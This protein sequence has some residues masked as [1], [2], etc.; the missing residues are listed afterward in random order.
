M[1][2]LSAPAEQEPFGWLARSD[3]AQ[4]KLVASLVLFVLTMLCGYLPVKTILNQR[5]IQY[6]IFAGGG[7]LMAT[8]FCHII[9]EAHDNYKLSQAAHLGHE[10][11]NGLDG[12]KQQVLEVDANANRTNHA[13][14]EARTIS[15]SS[16]GHVS[17]TES[18]KQLSNNHSHYQQQQQQP[19]ASEHKPQV[20]SEEAPDNNI[21]YVE[22]TICFGFFFIYLSEQL[23][24]RFIN[25]HTHSHPCDPSVIGAGLDQTHH[26]VIGEVHLVTDLNGASA[27][28]QLN[29][30]T[31][32]NTINSESVRV[33]RSN[34]ASS[35]KAGTELYKFI[36]GFLIVSAFI[37]HALFD[38]VAIGSQESVSEVWTVWFAICCHKL[39]IAAVVG[40][41]LFSAT[42]G[43]HLWTLFHLGLFSIMSPIGIILIV[44]A[45]SSLHIE[46]ND[47]VMVLLQAF[48]A[49]TLLYI[50]FIEILQPKENQAN[51]RNKL[52]KSVSLIIGF[53]L[54]TLVLTLTDV[55]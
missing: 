44:I 50:V 51:E 8:A 12:T 1:S 22:I 38:G 46:S 43:S 33:V 24:V 54:M 23:L 47:P 17:A 18:I 19:S 21:P 3:V 32:L 27:T 7:V 30:S 6:A 35:S 31:T 5:Y 41:E 36:R 10:H 49:G 45:Q 28:N 15:N 29:S 48:A 52:G 55:D 25:T 9:P 53:I 40:F 20:A 11:P 34:S 13:T 4:T 16:L 2:T 42:L 37:V 14:S 39:I 26:P